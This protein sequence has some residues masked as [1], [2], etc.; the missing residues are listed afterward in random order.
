MPKSSHLFTTFV[1]GLT[2][3]SYAYAH[4]TWLMP[5]VWPAQANFRPLDTVI[6]PGTGDHYPRP[7][8]Q[9]LLERVERGI[10]Q[11]DGRRE[12]KKLEEHSKLGFQLRHGLNTPYKEA[13]CAIALKAEG[14]EVEEALVNTYLA[15]ARPDEAIRVRWK[16]FQKNNKP[17]SET[18][19]KSA[20][21]EL[22][23]TVS[24][25]PLDTPLE[26]VALEPGQVS[27]V[28]NTLKLRLLLKGQALPNQ[29]V[30]WINGSND[31]SGWLSTNSLGE[32]M[33]PLN[34]PGRWMLRLI[35]IAP[36]PQKTWAFSTQFY[37][38]TLWV[39]P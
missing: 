3:G 32:L 13:S 1:L 6:F 25:T 16:Q 34:H 9:T 21:V 28:N 31:D 5:K 37:T 38:H 15:E 35:H 24:V 22:G 33:V 23:S 27:Q 8:F 19:V 18:Y 7:D 11:T 39:K 30:Q 14:I 17:W 36:D 4:D 29:N 12:M 10:C 20:K 26:L 2:L